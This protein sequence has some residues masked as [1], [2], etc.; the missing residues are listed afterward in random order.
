MKLF[1]VDS[2]CCIPVVD[3]YDV[4]MGIVTRSNLIQYIQSAFAAELGSE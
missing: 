1:N 2:V 4:P 3:E